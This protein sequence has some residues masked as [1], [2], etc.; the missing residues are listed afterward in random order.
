MTAK[1]SRLDYP[2]A[3]PATYHWVMA[4]AEPKAK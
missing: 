4:T 2:A 1:A 3:F